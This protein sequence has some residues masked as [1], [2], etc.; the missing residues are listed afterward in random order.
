VNA[1]SPD[2]QAI[3]TSP[4]PHTQTSGIDVFNDRHAELRVVVFS[5]KSPNITSHG[6]VNGP[7]ACRG[8]DT[9]VFL[10]SLPFNLVD[11]TK[12]AYWLEIDGDWHR[13]L[14][15]NISYTVDGFWQRCYSESPSSAWMFIYAFAIIVASVLTLPVEFL[16][17]G[18][19]FGQWIEQK[20]DKTHWMFATFGGILSVQRRFFRTPKR[21]RIP[22]FLTVIGTLCLPITFFGIDG[23][24]AIFYNWGYACMGRSI[25]QFFGMKF[26]ALY[27]Y[28]IV[29]PVV[30]FGSSVSLSGA[31]PTAAIV[32][33][34]VYIAS[35]GAW[36]CVVYMLVDIFGLIALCSP[37]FIV[38]PIYFHV[39]MILHACKCQSETIA[40]P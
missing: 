24:V 13:R 33:L 25:F 9:A 21:I 35:F 10:C 31:R 4:A 20:D 23:A 40:R 3:I 28:V 15:F 18:E 38:A 8:I 7:L 27:V 5:A 26:N 6:D 16:G 39:S 2:I 1:S 11:S 36:A 37:M 17:V 12:S 29:I 34:I 30:L 22:L 19:A 14:E 32:D